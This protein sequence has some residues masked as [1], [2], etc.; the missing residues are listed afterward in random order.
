[1]TGHSSAIAALEAFFSAVRR[2]AERDP[3]FASEL[4]T[5]L[6]I[7][8]EIRIESSAGVQGAML[9]LDPVVIAGKGLDEFR[10]VFGAMKDPD[11]RK[12][13]KAYNLAPAE[14]LT[15]KQ[16]PKGEALIELMWSAACAKRKRLEERR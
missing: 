3:A 2:Q 8:V 7:P 11:K 14:G 13:I 15:G 16:A 9:L 10:R 4:L 6:S 12:V 5:S 1:M